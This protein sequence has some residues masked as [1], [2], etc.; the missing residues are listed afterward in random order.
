MRA[1]KCQELLPEAQ[2]PYSKFMPIENNLAY[3]NYYE[4]CV[5]KG[6]PI[7]NGP[8]PPGKKQPK[9]GKGDPKPTPGKKQPKGDKGDPKSSLGKPKTPPQTTPKTPKKP[10]APAQPNKVGFYVTR[11]QNLRRASRC[12]QPLPEKHHKA[13][14]GTLAQ[15]PRY[16][17]FVKECK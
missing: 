1:R 3:Q 14:K 8:A 2:K 7:P 10:K 5:K 12:Q 17:K 6:T 15:D 11:E 13:V 9:G 16:I 4:E